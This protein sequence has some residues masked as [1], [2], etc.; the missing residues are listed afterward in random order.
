MGCKC[1]CNFILFHLKFTL[2][3]TTFICNKAFNCFNYHQIHLQQG[4]FKLSEQSLEVGLS[5]NFEVS[6]CGN[7]LL[8]MIILLYTW[9]SNEDFDADLWLTVRSK[10][11][12]EDHSLGGGYSNLEVMS[13]CIAMWVSLLPFSFK[14]S[15]FS[16]YILT[17]PSSLR[18][19]LL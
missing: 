5:Y 3:V 8:R 9:S 18:R 6:H 12:W 2:Q 15:L 10:P 4:N 14:V 1:F 7:Y 16:T 13:V 19:R 17:L 11:E